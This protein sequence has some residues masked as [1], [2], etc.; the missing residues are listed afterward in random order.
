MPIEEREKLKAGQP[1]SD[2]KLKT[3][4]EFT[5]ALLKHGGHPP[6]ESLNSFFAAGFTPAQSLEVILGIATKVLSNFT[7]GVA[8]TPLDEEVTH[9]K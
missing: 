5:S 1:L 4:Q 2:P 6:E 3:L 7:N 9:L 8:K